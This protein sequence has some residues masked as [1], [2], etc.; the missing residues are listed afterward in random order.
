MAVAYREAAL[1][2]VSFGHASRR[3]A[4]VSVAQR[5]SQ[6]SS[7]VDLT[8]GARSICPGWIKELADGLERFAAGEAVD[9]SDVPLELGHLT[10]FA[11]RV[12]AE[13]RRVGW[14][15]TSSYGEL[16]TAS[17]GP[18]AAR[19]VGSV[20]AKNRFPLIV[21][22]HRVLAAGGAI[23]GYSAPDGLTMKRRLLAMER[24]QIS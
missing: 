1:C 17:G 7:L 2:G 11:R 20:M 9:F 5:L 14:G 8:G 18:G 22:C 16:A 6:G 10:P 19:A 13:C 24:S 15:K 23:G 12:V 4:E 3:S 21:P